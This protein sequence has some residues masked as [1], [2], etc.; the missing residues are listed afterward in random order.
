MDAKLYHGI[1][2]RSGSGDLTQTYTVLIAGIRYLFEKKDD[3][4]DSL[5]QKVFEHIKHLTL[6]LLNKP[7]NTHRVL[8]GK[9]YLTGLDGQD[10][11]FRD[12]ELREISSTSL[13]DGNAL[14]KDIRK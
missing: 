5:R 6:A 9:S 7:Y 11:N 12:I 2:K 14:A 3:I 4:P 1:H 8:E 13:D 10:E